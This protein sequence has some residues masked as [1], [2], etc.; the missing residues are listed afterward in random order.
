MGTNK[1]ASVKKNA[2][3]FSCWQGEV[4]N[5]D[6]LSSKWIIRDPDDGKIVGSGYLCEDHLLMYEDD[7]YKVSKTN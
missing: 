4:E 5:N 7:G 1:E 2:R 6:V 3:C